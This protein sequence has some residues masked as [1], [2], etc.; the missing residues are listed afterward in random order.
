MRATTNGVGLDFIKEMAAPAKHP[1]INMIGTRLL[2]RMLARFPT[3]ALSPASG[4][5]P[6][7][8]AP[9]LQSI[10]AEVSASDRLRSLVFIRF[11]LL[12]NE[13]VELKSR[14]CSQ[15]QS[16]EESLP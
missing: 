10:K 5:A 15:N 12:V 11:S 16:K 8:N 1:Q 9:A 4:L 2:L 13:W 6:I 7:A 14:L 3:L